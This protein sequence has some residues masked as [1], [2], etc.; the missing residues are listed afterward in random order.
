MEKRNGFH[1]NG[2]VMRDILMAVIIAV[3]LGLAGCGEETAR[4]EENQ[5]QLQAMA[6]THTRQI[7]ALAAVIEQNQQELRS[8][9]DALK[10]DIQGVDAHALAVGEEYMK[11]QQEQVKL[12]EVV[13]NNTR[14]VTA[15]LA[16][17][18]R[19]QGDLMSGME[20]VQND[21]GKIAADVT[22]VSEE[23][24]RLYAGITAVTDEQARLHQTVQSNSRQLEDTSTAIDQ[25]RQES[26]TMMAD[27]RENIQQV[28]SNMNTLSS[29]LLKLQDVLQGNIR[30]LVSMVDASGQ[31]QLEFQEKTRAGL[32]ALDD[33]ISSMRESQNKLQSQINDVQSSTE[34]LSRDIP[35]VIEQLTDEISRI[36]TSENEDFTE[37]EPFS[38]SGSEG[39]E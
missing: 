9:I 15:K 16:V 14:Q 35:A 30:E 12:Q 25:S 11:M 28:A 8:V 4:I 38:S 33:S 22:S 32:Q 27:L 17:I 13:Q 21:T 23:Q 10:E 29:D 20:A 37:N 18:E 34:S 6:Q 2:L 39:I 1:L 3:G 36:S 31:G 19:N 7:N 24:A 5:I 26:Q